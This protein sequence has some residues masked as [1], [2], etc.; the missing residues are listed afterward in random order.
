ML[1]RLRSQAEQIPFDAVTYSYAAPL[2]NHIIGTG[3]GHAA[4]SDEALEQVAL[5]LDF[6]RFHCSECKHLELDG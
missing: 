1:Y 6:L 4:N 3:G 5:V 2:I